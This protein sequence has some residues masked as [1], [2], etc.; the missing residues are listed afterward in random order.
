MA[1]Q[2]GAGGG[3]A[4]APGGLPGSCPLG[5]SPPPPPPLLARPPAASCRCPRSRL[6]RGPSPRLPLPCLSAVITNKAGGVLWD[7]CST[8]GGGGVGWVV[9]MEHFPWVAIMGWTRL[10]E[11]LWDA[12]GAAGWGCPGVGGWGAVAGLRPTDPRGPR[13]RR[14]CGDPPDTG[15]GG[16]VA[17]TFAW[18]W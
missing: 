6:P 16:A 4:A 10:C 12:A 5:P 8:V 18:V 2:P 13:H 3:E 1:V 11:L 7:G 15:D 14:G 9:A 17:A